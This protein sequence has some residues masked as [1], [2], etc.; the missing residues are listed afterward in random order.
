MAIVLGVILF[1]ISSE[2]GRRN[3]SLTLNVKGTILMA[4]KDEETGEGFSDFELGNQLLTLLV[5]GF[6]TSANVL[7][8]ALYSLANN[9]DIQAKAKEEADRVLGDK[10]PTSENL[11]ELDYINRVLA[12]TMRLYPPV[13]LFGR[14]AL[15]DDTLG[16]F[17]IPQGSL[18]MVPP[19]VAHRNPKYWPDPERFDPDRHLPERRKDAPKFSY[20]PFGGG[21]RQCIGMGYAN[22]QMPLTIAHLVRL[23]KLSVPSDYTLRLRPAITLGAEE[24]IRLTIKAHPKNA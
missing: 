10:L 17:G 9:P 4:A 7:S 13:W 24:P 12:E 18:V 3:P 5:G 16:N 20:Y 14:N 2:E 21:P 23:F 15:E 6:D 8:F 22:T 11:H 19:F 1:S